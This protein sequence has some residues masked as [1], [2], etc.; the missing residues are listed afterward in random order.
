MITARQDVDYYQQQ[1]APNRQQQSQTKQ[2]FSSSSD[3]SDFSMANFTNETS[4]HRQINLNSSS[5]YLLNQDGLNS[6]TCDSDSNY[7]HLNKTN[8]AI[9]K[10]TD[11][12]LHGTS[13]GTDENRPE[14]AVSNNNLAY[15]V[16]QS[17]NRCSE[18]DSRTIMAPSIDIGNYNNNQNNIIERSNNNNSNN[19]SNDADDLFYGEKLL[20]Q[21]LGEYSG[22]LIR[23]GSPNMVC[24]ALPNHWRS[25]KTLP[26]T[27]KVVVLSEVPD[28]TLVTVRAGNDEN[29]CCDIRN[30]TATIK[31]QVAKFNDL[32]FVGRSGRG[33]SFSLTITVA[34]NPPLVATYN[35]AI[36]V[37]VDGPREPRRHN[38]P[39]GCQL[40][41]LSEK[42]DNNDPSRDDSNSANELGEQGE[43]H[44]L[45]NQTINPDQQT[46]LATKP[47]RH[48]S[49]R[50]YQLI[51][52]TE[53]WQPPVAS[54]QDLLVGARLSASGGSEGR[55]VSDGCLA[56]N[57]PLESEETKSRLAETLIENT[58]T[59][60][61]DDS[62]DL[63]GASDAGSSGFGAAADA[64]VPT[65]N[66]SQVAP[67][68]TKAS[69]I[70]NYDSPIMPETITCGP[71]SYTTTPSTANSFQFY[72]NNTLP[73]QN[74]IQPSYLDNVQQ[75]QPFSLTS[76][77]SQPM[78]EAIPQQTN[79]Q[80]RNNQMHSD[81][82][83]TN[84]SDPAHYTGHGDNNYHRLAH[85]DPSPTSA[86]Y[87]PTY[88]H[89]Q[90]SVGDTASLSTKAQA[91]QSGFNYERA[92]PQI[93]HQAN[94]YREPPDSNYPNTSAHSSWL[95]LNNQLVG[96]ISIE[97][98]N[99]NSILPRASFGYNSMYDDSYVK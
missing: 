64:A 63:N 20:N 98:T 81:P 17:N 70:E 71:N 45:K 62:A 68:I 26:S 38:Q 57:E 54:E 60:Q 6:A 24:S 48:K 22:E 97:Q 9:A 15:K 53:T 34:T 92:P 4:Y 79:Y 30:P 80:L 23:T 93:A 88:Q 90:A 37:T 86:Y 51:D 2:T 69:M 39:G 44:R 56:D 49:T 75:Q 67:Y 47:N 40:G 42:S 58:T 21:L 50:S 16:H 91:D 33:K 82:D 5:A 96:G 77:Q 55:P 84:N 18:M 66:Q 14:G 85:Y 35:K 43:H 94:A 76:R 19:S 65:S 1:V 36:K 46:Q 59:K 89:R 29:Y 99:P 95:G 61:A 10:S 27:F 11:E 41:Q 3:E 74:D 13:I 8:E 12:H 73:F 72:N 52:H 87:W 31:G 25:N 28:G 7:T 78:T 32:R 83:F